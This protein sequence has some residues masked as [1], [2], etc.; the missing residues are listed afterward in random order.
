MSKSTPIITQ[1]NSWTEKYKPIK[2]QDI[3]CNKK[4]ANNISDWL[5]TFEKEKIKF[6]KMGVTCQKKRTRKDADEPVVIKAKSCLLIT[7]NHGVGKTVTAEVILNAFDYNIQTVNFNNIK[8][9]KINKDYIK[10]LMKSSNILNVINDNT[11]CKNAILIDEIESITSTTEKSAILNLQKLNDINWYCPIIFISNNQHN[12]LLSEIKKNSLEVKF[13]PPFPSDIKNILRRVSSS[14][15]INIKSDTV[16]D[17]IVSHTQFDIR[18]LIYTLQDIKYAYN[19]QLITTD[20]INEYC[21]MS[22]KKDTDI[23]LFKATEQLLYNYESINDCLR[24]Y[25]TEKVL[26]PLMVHQNYVKSTLKNYQKKEDRYD[27]IKKV[28]QS[29]S[30]GDVVENYI[31]GDQNWDLQEI[32]GFHTCVATSFYLNNTN[33]TG[34]KLKLTK[35]KFTTDLNKTSIKKINKKNINNTNKCFKDMNIF[36]YIYINKIIRK[37]I[38]NN[39]IKECVD[40]LK[41][42]NIKL[43]HIESL[44]KIDKIETTNT[45]KIM[46]GKKP[47]KIKTNLTSKQKKEFM[48]Y[49]KN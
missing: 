9:G 1:A 5:K 48:K 20:L 13:Y 18:R 43:E 23:D 26:L 27:I 19:K 3:I 47:E 40:I 37:L 44:L 46:G 6:Q 39:E 41:E 30:Y 7:G 25:E 31:Y 35:L 16:M 33:N 12:K 45:S 38:E 34:E 8:G 10:K 4:A 28:S 11:G 15:G 2:Q 22:K 36:D 17:K 29:L 14:E 42:Y 24:Y 21:E 49:L 32:H